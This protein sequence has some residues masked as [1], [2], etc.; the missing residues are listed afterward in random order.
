MMCLFFSERGS[1]S[2]VPG[3]VMR[4]SH[5]A[6][7]LVCVLTPPFLVQLDGDQ[8]GDSEVSREILYCAYISQD[9]S[10]WPKIPMEE[11]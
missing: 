8:V 1:L 9:A 5:D 7:V 4:T 10:G 11:R 3:C 2:E 6:T